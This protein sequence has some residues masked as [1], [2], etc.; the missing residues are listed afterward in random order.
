MYVFHY[1]ILQSLHLDCS[2]E[3]NMLSLQNMHTRYIDIQTTMLL[4]FF[5]EVKLALD[6]FDAEDSQVDTI[7]VVAA[8]VVLI[9]EILVVAVVVVTLKLGANFVPFSIMIC[10]Q[11]IM[12]NIASYVCS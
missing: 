7:S 8:V 9:V 2:H 6:C 1:V 11:S 4:H 3:L 10:K 5:I 12:E